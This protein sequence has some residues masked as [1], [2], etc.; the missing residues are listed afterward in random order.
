MQPRFRQVFT[1]ATFVAGS[2]LLSGCSTSATIAGVWTASDGSPTKTISDDGSCTGMY[3][4]GATPLDIGGPMTC[5]LSDTETDGHYALV[6]QQSPNQA[7]YDAEFDGDTMV[8]S[9]GGVDIVTLTK[10]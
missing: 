9:S 6:V 3:Y 5:T 7:T 8:L 4:N 1:V 2:L 10:Q